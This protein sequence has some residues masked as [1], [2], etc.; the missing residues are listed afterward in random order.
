MSQNIMKL[1]Q[2][3]T[4]KKSGKGGEGVR[5]KNSWI[6]VAADNKLTL[7]GDGVYTNCNVLSLYF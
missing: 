1:A 4:R 2:L 3:E 5:D 6:F 7:T